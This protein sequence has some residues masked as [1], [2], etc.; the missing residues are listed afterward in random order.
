MSSTS[1]AASMSPGEDISDALPLVGRQ[2][3]PELAAFAGWP[4]LIPDN[5]RL[6]LA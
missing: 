4:M 1:T 5:V 3:S 6:E 2:L